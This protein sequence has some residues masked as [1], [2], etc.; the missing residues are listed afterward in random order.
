[1]TIHTKSAA[2]LDGVAAAV[3]A[4]SHVDGEHGEL[5]V[6]G[7]R[8]GDLAERTDFEGL[9][10]RLWGAASA[11]PVDETDV[12]RWLGTRSTRCSRLFCAA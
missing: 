9:V 12:R 4:L 5:I 11:K 3:T 7:T 6:A 2:G 10:A 1:M 8:I